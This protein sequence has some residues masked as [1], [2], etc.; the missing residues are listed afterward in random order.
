[1][2]V[3]RKNSSS[4]AQDYQAGGGVIGGVEPGGGGLP[5]GGAQPVLL[6]VLDG[7]LVWLLILALLEAVFD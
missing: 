4:F 6:L 5:P 2:I 7:A 1:M 3:F